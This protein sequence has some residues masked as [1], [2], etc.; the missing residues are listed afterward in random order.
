[1]LSF[2]GLQTKCQ[3]ATKDTSSDALDFF[4]DEINEG[5]R[6]VEATLG[7]FYTEELKT[8]LTVADQLSYKTPAGL[9]FLKKAYITISN[10]RYPL[11]VVYSED[12]W[13]EYQRENATSSSDILSGIFVRRDNFEVY[14]TPASSGNTMTLIFESGNNELIS[15]DYTTGTHKT[16]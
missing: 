12:E 7:S 3:K 10:T 5:Q 14:Q 16:R 8:V 1:M 2:T 13:Q 9:I 4:K 15:D 6:E 11:D